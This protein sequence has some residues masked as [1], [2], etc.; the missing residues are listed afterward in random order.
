MSVVR[1]LSPWKK[2]GRL[3]SPDPNVS[4]MSTFTGASFAIPLDDGPLFAIYVTGRDDKNRS[5][6]GKIK[7]D[8]ENPISVIEILPKPVF[9]LGELG[10]FDENG[11]SYPSMVKYDGYWYLYYVGWMP[12]VLTP[13]QNHTGLARSPVG[14]DNFERVSRAPILPRTHE[15]PFGTGS[16][17]VMKEDD[18]WRLWYTVWLRW[19]TNP[20]DHKH[21]YVI[22]HADSLDG[23]NWKRNTHICINYK[24]ESEYAIAK[25]SVIKIGNVYH[26]WFAYRGEYYRIGYAYSHDG[27]YWERRD[28]WAGI[29][30]S[31]AGWDSKAISYPHVFRCLDHLYMLYC[32]NEYGK[33]GLGLA[34]LKLYD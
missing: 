8:I 27:L 2:L 25:P 21:Y 31:E 26:M 28:E 32:G 13:F 1:W 22:R 33:E 20:D 17:C 19:G 10:A 24:D 9:C 3:L 30:V 5:Q 15:E 34:T 11:V 14:E 7:I 12:T 23:L 29:D 4:W 6:I 16:V 18:R